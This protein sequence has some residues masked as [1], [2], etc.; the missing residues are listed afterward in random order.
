MQ[1]IPAALLIILLIATVVSI[2]TINP[3]ESNSGAIVVPDDFSTIEAA[4]NSASD[5][6]TI[7]VKNGIYPVVGLT[8]DKSI[9]L[10]GEDSCRT[11]LDG[12]SETLY[13]FPSGHKAISIRA[14]NVLIS[15]FN[16]T[17]C[18]DGIYLG[19]SGVSI[20]GNNINHNMAGLTGGTTNG[21]I[22]DNTFTYNVGGLGLT[23]KD[24]VIS[25]NLFSHNRASLGLSSSH[26][27]I[28]CYNRIIDN[29]YGLHLMLNSNL[30][31]FGNSITG[32]LDSSGSLGIHVPTE[33]YGVWFTSDNNGTLIYEN[34]IY[35]NPRGII[36]ADTSGWSPM[37][38]G[39]AIFKN[40]FY[41]NNLNANA[42]SN[43]TNAI[44]WFHNG[45]GNYWSDYSGNGNYTIAQ[46]HVDYYPLT[47]KVAVGVP[48]GSLDIEQPSDFNLPLLVSVVS[49]GVAIVAA[50]VLLV[51]F[52]RHRH[53]Q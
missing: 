41:E 34:N 8:I 18:D 48:T 24:S 46:G 12:R 23:C 19:D 35:R 21:V 26:D 16:I 3:P 20:I 4:I 38:L 28:V 7:F 6:D 36:I 44:S 14:P 43:V 53:R 1:K 49:G 32:S 37:G 30:S 40:N 13:L 27:V 11:I 10:I 5:G 45:V 39:N 29:S 33:G 17:N 52:W 50:A 25:N 9:S 51:Y 22:S 15:G 2:Y 47:E 31:I 42:T